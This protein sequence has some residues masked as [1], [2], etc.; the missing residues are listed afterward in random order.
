M[1]KPS[2]VLE[3]ISRIPLEDEAAPLASPVRGLLNTAF[4]QK[5]AVVLTGLLWPKS[6]LGSN[7]LPLAFPLKF[8]LV[9]EIAV[10]LSKL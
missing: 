9:R 4:R 7:I 6:Y 5:N 8:S 3:S 1:K 2:V 10:S